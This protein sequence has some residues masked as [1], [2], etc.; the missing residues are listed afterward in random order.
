MPAGPSH[1]SVS[2]V[3]SWSSSDGRSR[4]IVVGV[5]VLSSGPAP[6][7]RL[8]WNGSDRGAGMVASWCRSD[9]RDAAQGE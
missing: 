4:R 1:P 7:C 5:V 6:G 3:L 8:S 9:T 2:M